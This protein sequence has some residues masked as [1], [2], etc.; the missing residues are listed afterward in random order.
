MM[1][2]AERRA[3][4]AAELSLLAGRPINPDDYL[5]PVLRHDC[6]PCPFDY[7]IAG[8]GCPDAEWCKTPEGWQAI[9]GLDR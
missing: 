8:V 9:G 6:P 7:E 3:D 4:A 1:P 5:S 2:D